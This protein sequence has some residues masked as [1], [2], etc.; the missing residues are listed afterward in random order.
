MEHFDL[1]KP[2]VVLYQV[3]LEEISSNFGFYPTFVRVSCRG[4]M[5]SEAFKWTLDRDPPLRLPT[6]LPP[7]THNADQPE[8]AL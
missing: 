4:G 1:K 2:L 7:K 3:Y 5:V 8:N 6:N